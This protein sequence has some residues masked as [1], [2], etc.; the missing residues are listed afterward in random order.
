MKSA[1]SIF[2]EIENTSGKNDKIAIIKANS[3][4]SEFREYL[5]FLYDDMIV[6]GLSSKKIDK[7]VNESFDTY[8]L[9]DLDVLEYLK[10]NNL[11]FNYCN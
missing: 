6:T 10:I 5:K 1:Y 3:D 8:F 11:Y 9:N 4:N 7:Q 2:K